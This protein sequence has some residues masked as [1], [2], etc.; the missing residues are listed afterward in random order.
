MKYKLIAI[1]MDGTL[2]NSQNK[3]SER[4]IKALQEAIKRGIYVVLAT[5]RIL[6]S[7]LYYS[8]FLESNN[9]II[10]CNGAIIYCG[11]GKDII[12]EKT[13]GVNLS[14]KIIELAE[15]NNLYYHFYNKDT[16][17]YKK[18]DGSAKKYY[19]F[20]GDNIGKQGIKFKA[21][22]EPIEVLNGKELN[23]Y[24]FVFIEDDKDKLLDFREKL[25]S[26]EKIN[27]SSSWSNNIEVMDES[28]S[29]GSGLKHLCKS[30]NIDR[31]QV[32][33]IGDNENDI[34]MFEMSGLA[35]AMENGDEIAKKH[36]HVVTDT[37]DQNGVAK[38]IEEY[39]LI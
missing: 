12:Y 24:K 17:Y 20:Y 34:S 35:I 37:N 7:A 29:K 4:N 25:K 33:A 19:K 10:A 2:L 1:D 27:I 14:K 3:I 8:K 13:I 23:I 36:S 28:V 38:A 6:K 21:L 31:S 30:L 5:G 11:Y 16:F 15:E 18:R 26:I 22:K 32:V 9:P 39:V